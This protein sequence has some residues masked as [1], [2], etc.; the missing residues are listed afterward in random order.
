[1]AEEK[2]RYRVR[3]MSAYSAGDITNEAFGS[4]R[5]WTGVT[6]L[7]WGG[8][9]RIATARIRDFLR[10]SGWA[11]SVVDRSLEMEVG[12]RLQ[13]LPT[14]N[15]RGLG[16]SQEWGRYAKRRL[17]HLWKIYAYG[18]SNNFDAQRRQSFGASMYTARRH[19]LVESDCFFLR[20]WRPDDNLLFSTCW[21]QIHPDRVNQPHGVMQTPKLRMGV[22]MNANG[23]PIAYHTSN[24][25][26]GE[27]DNPKALKWTRHRRF[28]PSGRVRMIHYYEV[29]DVEQRRGVSFLTT[30]AEELAMLKTWNRQQVFAAIKRAYFSLF[31]RSS[32]ETEVLKAALAPDS[33]DDLFEEMSQFRSEYYKQNGI[34]I[35]RQGVH[36]LAPNDEIEMP[37]MGA[38]DPNAVNFEGGQ[39]RQ[40]AA[41]NGA[42]TAAVSGNYTELNYSSGRLESNN[43][44]RKFNGSLSDFSH[45]VP[46][47]VYEAFVEECVA[48]GYLELPGD[49]PPYALFKDLYAHARVIGPGRGLIDGK[50]DPEGNAIRVNTFQSSLRDVVAETGGD[51]DDILDETE[52]DADLMEE[53][54]FQHPAL[55]AR[56][57]IADD[58]EGYPSDED[59]ADSEEDDQ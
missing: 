37:N 19:T 7:E 27:T 44:Y 12:K 42:P 29:E 57:G 8:D 10:N 3:A 49:A 48:A 4:R 11:K 47:V 14:P 46:L 2:P 30:V 28:D 51:L 59:A 23:V 26:E 16:L 24:K 35:S 40:I 55:A 43:A 13:V 53:M 38:T 20:Q 31:I 6:D 21:R 5:V 32:Q 36:V 39:L 54:G 41:A 52:D 50:K 1:M 18:T 45:G 56:A 33:A 22:E 17:K 15:Y 34:D 9:R 25:M 58:P